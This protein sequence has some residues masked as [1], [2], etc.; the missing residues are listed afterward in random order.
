MKVA[1]QLH[2][3]KLKHSI[4]LYILLFPSILLLILFSYIPMLG[5]IIAF[6]DYSP[7]NGIF[8]SQWVGFKYFTQFFSSFQFGTTMFNTL[9]ISLYSI[10]VG[11]PLPI[12]L[13]IISNQLRVGKFRKIFQV[14]TY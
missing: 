2:K 14:T 1:S 9:K 8:A 10:V 3:I 5:L 7:A 6:K 12:I 11:F 4:P 13:A